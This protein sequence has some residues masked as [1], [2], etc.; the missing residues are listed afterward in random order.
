[1]GILWVNEN[2]F[3]CYDEAS[4]GDLRVF[5]KALKGQEPDLVNDNSLPNAAVTTYRS[6]NKAIMKYKNNP[7]INSAQ[8][9]VVDAWTQH[10]MRSG[11][12]MDVMTYFIS[13]FI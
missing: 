1:M 9:F 5:Y 8:I 10:A 4:F 2:Q 6:L 12:R 13:Y 3:P 11:T 7:I